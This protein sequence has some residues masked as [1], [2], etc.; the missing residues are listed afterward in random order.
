MFRP[1]VRRTLI[2][3]ALFFLFSSSVVQA[4]NADLSVKITATPDAMAGQPL[5]YS[6]CVSNK[7]QKTTHKVVLTN[8]LPMDGCP[9]ACRTVR[10][11]DYF[12]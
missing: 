11:P 10:L 12:Q 2:S 4:G 9:I 7:G 8:P 1:T 3:P 6:L 5:T